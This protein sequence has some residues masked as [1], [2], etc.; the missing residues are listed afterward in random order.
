MGV[1]ACLSELTLVFCLP[2]TG[3]Y[4]VGAL[5]SQAFGLGLE[6]IVPALLGPQVADNSLWDFSAS[7]IS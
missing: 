6:F 3:T 1:S 7:I 4:D 2:Y 5:V